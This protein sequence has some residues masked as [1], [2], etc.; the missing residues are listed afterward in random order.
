M[1]AS[2][3]C[4]FYRF[5][6]STFKSDRSSHEDLFSHR[7]AKLRE[8]RDR[9]RIGSSAQLYI[10]LHLLFF[11]HGASDQ[12]QEW[13]RQ[14]FPSLARPFGQPRRCRITV[15]KLPISRDP[16]H[17][18]GILPGK[19]RQ[20]RRTFMGCTQRLLGFLAFFDF[21]PQRRIR[22]PQI[23]GPLFHPFL[24]FFPALLQGLLCPLPLGYLSF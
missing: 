3:S 12:R 16:Y 2:S 6:I 17:R 5:S 19:S 1:T 7:V 14:R 11:Y 15:A 21:R 9:N 24:Q 18:I 22:P 13:L 20:P 8:W 4:P 23:P 10:L